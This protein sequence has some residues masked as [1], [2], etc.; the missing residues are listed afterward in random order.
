[1]VNEIKAVPGRAGRSQATTHSELSQIALQLF[2]ERGFDQT[3]VDEIAKAAGVGRRTLF[4]YFQTKNDLP[5][6]NFDPLLEHMRTTLARADRTV[7]II[8]ALREA[9]IEFNSFPDD[10]LDMHRSRMRLLLNVPT[11]MAYSTLR[12]AEWRQ[13]IAEFVAERLGMTP[14]DLPPQTIAWTSLGICLAA[15]EHWLDSEDDDLID[16]LRIAFANAETIFGAA[17]PVSQ[18]DVRDA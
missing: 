11:L 9:V 12:Y 8:D 16:T 4:R 18:R 14:N 7:P 17:V 13:V 1:M 3:T 5:W 6:G 15:Y 10:E 2:I